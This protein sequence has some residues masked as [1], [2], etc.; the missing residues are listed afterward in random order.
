[1]S[2]SMSVSSESSMLDFVGAGG[3]LVFLRLAFKFSIITFAAF[4]LAAFWESVLLVT[5]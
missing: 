3:C 2:V 5:A 1:M 4:L